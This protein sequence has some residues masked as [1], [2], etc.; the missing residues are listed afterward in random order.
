MLPRATPVLAAF[1]LSLTLIAGPAR[2]CRLALAL[3][4]DVSFSVDAA[5]YRV[6]IDGIIAALMDREV[7]DLLVRPA[8]PVALAVFEWSAQREQ[9]LV[10]D[11]T[12]LDS[13]AAIDRAAQTIL[14]HHRA[15]SSLTAVG[16]ALTYGHQLLDRAPECLWHTLDLA[17][18]GQT[19]NGT[20]PQRIYATTD[21]G[22]IV[23]NGLAIGGHE[24]SI[25]HW[26]ETNVLHG[27]GAFVEFARTHA[28]F[29]A[30]FRRKLIREL[31]EPILGAAGFGHSG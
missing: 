14:A 9:V 6:Q 24:A 21:F 31:S 13:A 23:V 29:A 18:D 10:L 2:A 16:S 26:F 19:N 25:R 27:P 8:E 3:G 11:W 30:A 12:L 7:R 22:D 15:A 20:D 17:G 28:E 5:D 1:V 4:F